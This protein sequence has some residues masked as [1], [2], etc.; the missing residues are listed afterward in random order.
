MQLKLR[1]RARKRATRRGIDVDI[2]DN[3]P[4]WRAMALTSSLDR[5][6]TVNH[7]ML[8]TAEDARDLIAQYLD[9]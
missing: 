5:F 4:D 3:K 6:K 9:G 7:G 2:G 8:R 1:A